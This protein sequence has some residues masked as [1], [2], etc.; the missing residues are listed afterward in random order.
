MLTD[1]GLGLKDGERDGPLSDGGAVRLPADDEP[2]REAGVLHHL[3]TQ[4]T[5]YGIVHEQKV[6]F[7]FFL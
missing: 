5:V 3:H 1:R 7:K 4:N 6:Y 2:T